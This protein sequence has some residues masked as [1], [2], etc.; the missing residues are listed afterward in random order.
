MADI[1]KILYEA[2]CNDILADIKTYERSIKFDRFQYQTANDMKDQRLKTNFL[3]ECE[4]AVEST[5]RI[6]KKIVERHVNAE[7]IKKRILAMESNI[8]LQPLPKRNFISIL[9]FY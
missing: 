1:M 8:D 5:R 6:G 9:F 7:N 3:R 2:L 4:A